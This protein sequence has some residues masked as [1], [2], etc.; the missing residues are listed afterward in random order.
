M[1]S[2]TLTP[3]LNTFSEN[4][5]FLRYNVKCDEQAALVIN[6]N[7][8]LTIRRFFFGWGEGGRFPSVVTLNFLGGGG[9]KKSIVLIAL[10]LQ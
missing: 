3:K 9:V 6:T 1:E 7:E 2:F 10:T 4:Y 8:M 5:S